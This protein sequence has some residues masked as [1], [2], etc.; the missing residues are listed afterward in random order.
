M[1]KQNKWQVTGRTE[2]LVLLAYGPIRISLE[3]GVGSWTARAHYRNKPIKR[4]CMT[5]RVGRMEAA[6]SAL[7]ALRESRRWGQGPL[8]IIVEAQC[9][10]K[11]VRL[12]LEEGR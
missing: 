7:A 8:S 2:G 5:R 12:L 10:L 3:Q 6:E 4:G 11:F 1:G 9:H